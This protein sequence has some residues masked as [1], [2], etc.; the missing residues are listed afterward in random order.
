[1]QLRYDVSPFI[2]GLSRLQRKEAWF[3]NHQHPRLDWNI[4]HLDKMIRLWTIGNR[5][6]RIIL[7]SWPGGD[8]QDAR[9]QTQSQKVGF[10]KIKSCNRTSSRCYEAACANGPKRFH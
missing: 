10:L 6:I 1:M 4:V 8:Q 2:N 5:N 7:V 3:T 9:G